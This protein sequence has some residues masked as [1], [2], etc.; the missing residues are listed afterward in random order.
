LASTPNF[1]STGRLRSRFGNALL[2]RD[3]EKL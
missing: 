3:R 1:K 2:N